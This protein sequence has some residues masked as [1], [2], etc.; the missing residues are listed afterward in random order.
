MAMPLELGP[1]RVTGVT[2]AKAEPDYS[3]AAEPEQ[4]TQAAEAPAA[5][6]RQVSPTQAPVPKFQPHA[7]G[8]ARLS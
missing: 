1:V 6:R 2:T 5:E 8:T 7:T 4:K 3:E